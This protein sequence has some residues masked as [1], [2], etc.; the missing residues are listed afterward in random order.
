MNPYNDGKDEVTHYT[1][2]G[3]EITFYDC[4]NPESLWKRIV[5]IRVSD[6]KY[7]LKHGIRV[8]MPS[9]SLKNYLRGET[10]KVGKHRES[11]MS[12]FQCRIVFTTK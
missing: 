9:M 1:Y 12:H 2:P 8:G 4:K 7:K 10:A 11:I 6:E 5:E 3:L